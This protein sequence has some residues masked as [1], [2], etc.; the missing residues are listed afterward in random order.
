MISN[1]AD[2]GYNIISYSEH[3]IPWLEE[4]RQVS[5]NKDLYFFIDQFIDAIKPMTKVYSLLNEGKHI[6]EVNKELVKEARFLLELNFWMSLQEIIHQNINFGII[7]SRRRYS[8]QKISKKKVERAYGIISGDYRIRIDLQN[9]GL[10][11]GKGHFDEENNW[12]WTQK[13]PL[14]EDV[15]S[16]NSLSEAKELADQVFKQF[17]K[18]K[19]GN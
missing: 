19:S 2:K 14:A 5:T 7:D 17:G 3:I 12:G 18:F 16:L 4:V 9:K 8:L 10:I 6:S 11:I 15:K 1:D 13:E